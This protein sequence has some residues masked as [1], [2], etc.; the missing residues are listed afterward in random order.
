MPNDIMAR[1]TRQMARWRTGFDTALVCSLALVAV[2]T[3]VFL[4]LADEVMEGDTHAFDQGILLAFRTPGH[5]EQPLG[6]LWFQEMA[7]DVTS[8]GSFAVLGII[9]IGTVG[10]LLLARRRWAAIVTG[11]SVLGGTVISQVLKSGY[12]RPRPDLAATAHVFTASFPSG[13][14]M[15]SSVTYLTLGALLASTAQ[16][17]ATRIFAI[18]FA[19]ALTLLVG[20]S[21][22]YLGVHYATDVLAGWCL[23]SAWA[24]FCLAITSWLRRVRRPA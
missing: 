19:T 20:L 14:A 16:T 23:G 11:I 3:G 10:Y 6:P 21:R 2:L 4:A 17:R 1:V 15:L 18:A 12:D 24:A 9:F 13:H 22:L 5:P 7:R 8:L